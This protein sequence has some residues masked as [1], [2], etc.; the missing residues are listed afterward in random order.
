[1]ARTELG[2]Q[3]TQAHR[4]ALIRLKAATL[5][6]L[7][8]LYPVWKLDDAAS[9]DRLVEVVGMLVS[10]RHANAAALAAAYYQAF[11]QIEKLPGAAV[12]AALAPAPTAEM[13]RATVNA[14]ARAGVA[15][16]LK[17]GKPVEAAMQNGYVRL[18]GAV[19]RDVLNGSRDT[20]METG[21]ADSQ[22]TG[23]SRVTGGDPC[24]FCA[25]I[26]SS[27][28]RYFSEDTAGFE[29]HDHCDC[30][31]EPYSEG[32]AWPGINREL[33]D[34]WDAATQGYSGND[35]LNA[36]RRSMSGSTAE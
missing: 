31:A 35:A 11:R 2:A 7:L 30:S 16:A 4:Q 34:K 22:F 26:A 13:I 36:F 29:A 10:A 9:Y 5:R 15:T 12:P 25:M 24:S 27:G 32:S 33:R 19:G 21:R 6:D 23:W 14:T 8:S 17:A 1:M 20:I 3:L 18:S 28:P